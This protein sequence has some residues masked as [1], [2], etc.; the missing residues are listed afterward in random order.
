MCRRHPVSAASRMSRAISAYSLSD[1]MPGKPCARANAP[2][3]QQPPAGMRASTSQWAATKLP[4]AATRSIAA[5]I[6]SSDRTPRP[7]SEKPATCGAS[8]ATSESASPRRPRVIA[9]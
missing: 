7:S 2:S 6:V 4:A 5:R 9:A 1:G 8:A 3:W